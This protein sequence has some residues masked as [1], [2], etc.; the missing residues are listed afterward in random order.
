MVYSL[1]SL[2]CCTARPHIHPPQKN[3][4]RSANRNATPMSTHDIWKFQPWRSPGL[5]PVDDPCG[6]AGGTPDPAYNGGE[7]TPTKY[8]KQGDLGSK[9]LKPRPTGIAWKAG[10]VA[11]VSWYEGDIDDSATS[12]LVNSRTLMGVHRRP[13]LSL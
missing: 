8:A 11:N 1:F 3:M 5:A 13:F 10:G 7:Y 6:M 2:L 4:Y 9:Q 12:V